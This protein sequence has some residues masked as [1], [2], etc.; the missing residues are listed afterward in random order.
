MPLRK[1]RGNRTA[2][3]LG[4]DPLA[5]ASLDQLARLRSSGVGDLGH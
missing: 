3:D 1:S 4:D 5:A 2:F